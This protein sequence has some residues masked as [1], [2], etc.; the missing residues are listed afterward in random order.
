MARQLCQ[1]EP[2]HPASAR[3]PLSDGGPSVI[4]LFPS[5]ETDGAPLLLSPIPGAQCADRA[6]GI[7]RVRSRTER[8]FC[9]AILHA[10]LAKLVSIG[11]RLKRAE[12]CPA[13]SGWP[14]RHFTSAVAAR[15]SVRA[16]GDPT[17]HAGIVTETVVPRPFSLSI[18]SEPPWSSARR[19]ANGKPKPVPSKWRL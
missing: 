13:V 16:S 8:P 2:R 12:M 17:R 19:L 14:P 18:T 4:H 11:G 9:I 6:A 3:A 5:A 1:F 15:A 10:N 7:D